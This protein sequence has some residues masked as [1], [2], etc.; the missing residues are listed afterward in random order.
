MPKKPKQEQPETENVLVAAAKTIGKA[1]GTIAHI[2]GVSP[3]ETR[4]P[5][6]QPKGKLP[7]KNKARLPR[8][9]KKAQKKANQAA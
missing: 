7:K 5:K 3:S 4:A 9:V 8:K 1:A 2:A 6:A